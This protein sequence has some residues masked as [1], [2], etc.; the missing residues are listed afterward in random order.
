MLRKAER[1]VCADRLLTEAGL[2][3]DRLT[4][5]YGTRVA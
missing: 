3:R 1:G 4:V 2:R 5:R